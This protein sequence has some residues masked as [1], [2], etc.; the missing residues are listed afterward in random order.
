MLHQDV[1]DSFDAVGPCF[2]AFP[3]IRH[4]GVRACPCSVWFQSN[5]HLPAVLSAGIVPFNTTTYQLN[6]IQKT[7]KARTGG[8]P[9]LGRG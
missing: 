4:P 8:I 6:D 7:M 2:Q 1:V 5:N 3:Y 9:Y